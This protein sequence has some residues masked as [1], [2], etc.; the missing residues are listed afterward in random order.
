[1]PTYN[2]EFTKY[3]EGKVRLEL[4]PPRAIEGLGKVLTMGAEK[5]GANNWRKCEDTERYMGAA[6]RHI[7]ARRQGELVDPE[8]G[9]DHLFHAMTN[10]MFITELT[11]E[12]QEDIAKELNMALFNKKSK[13]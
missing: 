6:L 9:L 13:K 2:K 10:L 7:N 8:S 5:Y 3:D 12:L 11:Q 1:M 4:V